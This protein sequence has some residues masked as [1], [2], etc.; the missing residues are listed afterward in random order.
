MNGRVYEMIH[1]CLSKDEKFQIRN[2]EKRFV[3]RSNGLLNKD[4]MLICDESSGNELIEIRKEYV[5]IHCRFH[6][7]ANKKDLA[8]IHID[9]SKKIFE[10]DSID[11][12]YHVEHLNDE[13]FQ[14]KFSEK[15]LFHFVKKNCLSKEK[16]SKLIIYDEDSSKD[17]FYISIVIVLFYVD[18]FHH[19]Q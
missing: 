6:L 12:V 2:D 4:Q 9:H 13:T 19:F 14:L 10:I 8:T 16:C 1:Q 11:G 15:I 5:H 18:R 17:P 7:S 3:V